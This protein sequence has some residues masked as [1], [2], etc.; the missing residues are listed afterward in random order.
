MVVEV[1]W[2]RALRLPVIELYHDAMEDDGVVPYFGCVGSSPLVLP[3][4]LAMSSMR[5]LLE[6]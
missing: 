3:H 1:P 5:V 4:V 2:R 6:E